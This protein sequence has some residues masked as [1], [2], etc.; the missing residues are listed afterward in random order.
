MKTL[1]FITDEM[2]Q[3]ALVEV[4][5]IVENKTE[6]EDRLKVDILTMSDVIE[7]L[8]SK[9]FDEKDTSDYDT[10]G[11]DCDMFQIMYYNGQVF[12]ISA[13]GYYGG[14]EIYYLDTKE[15]YK[16]YGGEY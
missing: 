3:A 4:W 12:D 14:V 6:Y 1:K 16:K 8:E 7:F 9:G 10:N 13:S 11:W 2:K 5:K 15:N